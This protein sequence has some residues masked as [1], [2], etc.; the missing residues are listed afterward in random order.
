MSGTDNGAALRLSTGAA[1]RTTM[2]IVFIG[3]RH[4]FSN[5]MARTVAREIED[6]DVA[7][8]EDLGEFLATSSESPDAARLV[9]IDPK[10][11]AALLRL[12]ADQLA[13][14]GTA[15]RAVAY[16]DPSEIS[17]I[18]AR[19]RTDARITGFL[20]MRVRLDIWLSII[21]LLASGGSHV[22]DELV[23]H[24]AANGAAPTASEGAS[25]D[26]L[27]PRENE[28]L[29]LVAQGIQNK[30]I[31]T[32]LALSEHT[33]KLHIHHIISKLGVS[34]RTEAAAHFFERLRA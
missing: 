24:A 25:L 11:A 23:E 15:T 7:R 3:T 1:A 28:V 31:A 22:P 19:L 26:T 16:E 33:V 32:T 5:C 9:F 13:R 6:A 18:F 27:T 14:F 4:A 34:N 8:F 21:R 12:T 17:P 10:C 20:P 29:Q 30:N 2:R